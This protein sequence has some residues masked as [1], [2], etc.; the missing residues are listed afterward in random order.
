MSRWILAL[1]LFGLGCATSPAT[2]LGVE[3]SAQAAR[4]AEL[5]ACWGDMAKISNP[6]A[7][8]AVQGCFAKWARESCAARADLVFWE[9]TRLSA[10]TRGVLDAAGEALPRVRETQARIEA[11]YKLCLG[12][13]EQ[14]D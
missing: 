5:E 4:G 6:G 11:D 3:Q 8:P 1:S 7:S 13:A 9:R 10:R 14:A 12:Y 2:Q